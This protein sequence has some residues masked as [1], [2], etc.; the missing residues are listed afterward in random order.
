MDLLQHNS[1][2]DNPSRTW[3]RPT[4]VPFFRSISKR[5]TPQTPYQLINN[6]HIGTMHNAAHGLSKLVIGTPVV[7]QNDKSKLWDRSG[8]VVDVG[9]HRKYFIRLP[10]GRI[11]TR[12]RRFLRRRYSPTFLSDNTEQQQQLPSPPSNPASAPVSSTKQ[13]PRRSTRVKKKPD[14]L[15]EH[16]HL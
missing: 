6:Q 2:L 7:I 13:Q 5:P 4:I 1:C 10:S 14:R 11:L 8:V 15:I 3:Y 12:N 16:D 9:S